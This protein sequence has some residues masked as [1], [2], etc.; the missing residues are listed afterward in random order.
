MTNL[1]SKDRPGGDT[2]WRRRRRTPRAPSGA[3][4]KENF[5]G[6]MNGGASA[7]AEEGGP[8]IIRN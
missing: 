1:K 8:I 6:M 5:T 7:A 2:R 4:F 3:P